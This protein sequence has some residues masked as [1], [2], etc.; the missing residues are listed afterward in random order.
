MTDRQPE[1]AS[2]IVVAYESRPPEPD[3]PDGL[4]HV[5][6]AIA[7]Y[8][9]PPATSREDPAADVRA[10]CATGWELSERIVYVEVFDAG[11]VGLPVGW[12]HRGQPAELPSEPPAERPAE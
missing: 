10:A 1:P 2:L 6:G 5:G 3:Q 8:P 9:V 11:N 4:G 7:A 12:Q